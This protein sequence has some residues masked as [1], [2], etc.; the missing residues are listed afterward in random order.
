[1]D[2]W[3]TSH[4]FEFGFL[5][6]FFKCVFLQTLMQFI[7]MIQVYKQINEGANTVANSDV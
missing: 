5:K 3:R 1:M 4:N 2:V 7:W 6:N